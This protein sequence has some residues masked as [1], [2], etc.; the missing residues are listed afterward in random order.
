MKTIAMLGA[1]SALAAASVAS[2]GLSYSG[3]YDWNDGGTA[4]GSYGSNLTLSNVVNP[5]FGGSNGSLQMTEDPLSG[6]PQA[7]VSWITGLNDGDTIDV[8]MLGLGDGSST[9]KIRL[10]AHYTTGD[11]TTYGGSASG[12][13]DYSTS[14]TEWTMLSNTWTFNSDGGNRNGIVIEARLYAYSGNENPS[15]WV[16]DITVDVFSTSDDVVINFPAPVPAPAALALLGLA[17]L[18]G[19]RRRRN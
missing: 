9:G 10:W 6:T 4:L 5:I 3:S 2:A 15:G 16:D 8:S 18:A 1:V 13:S 14:T 12:P 11:I 7:Y 17:G 19:G